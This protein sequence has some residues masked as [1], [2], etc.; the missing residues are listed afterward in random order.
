MIYV[1]NYVTDVHSLL[2]SSKA[3]IRQR[4]CLCLFKLLM[5]YPLGLLTCYPRMKDLLSDE[6]V[7]V[8]AAAVST[9]LELAIR[10]PKNYLR[11]APALYKLVSSV[12]SQPCWI[13]IKVLK[14][15]RLLCPFED[16]LAPKLSVVLLQLL[17]SDK[18]GKTT[19][20]L[21]GIL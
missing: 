12:P 6:D 3:L 19:N 20:Q 9:I 7:S 8:V 15:F 1:F 17:C 11:L 14:L 10:N 5:K 18:T 21:F 4:A 13:V 16:R 2:S